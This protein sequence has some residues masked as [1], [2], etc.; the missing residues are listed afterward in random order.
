MKKTIVLAAACCCVAIAYAATPGNSNDQVAQRI[1]EVYPQ[2]D[3]NG[4]GVLSK[5]E[6]TAV[7]R[8]ALKRYPQ[9]DA[10]GD[11]KLSQQE[12]DALLEKLGKTNSCLLYT[13]DAADE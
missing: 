10:D 4:D 8:L 13:S 6:L 12:R 2:A 3:T 1:L 9:A 11:G 5:A 7:G